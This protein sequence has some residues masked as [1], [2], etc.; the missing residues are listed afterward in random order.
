MAATKKITRYRC[1]TNI[2]ETPL[3][4]KDRGAVYDRRLFPAA[5]RGGTERTRRLPDRGPASN[6]ELPTPSLTA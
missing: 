3:T 2:I 5:A 1:N 6:P 4:F